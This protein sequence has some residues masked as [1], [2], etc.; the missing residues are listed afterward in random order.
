[1][2]NQSTRKS[3]YETPRIRKMGSFRKETKALNRFSAEIVVGKF[4]P[5]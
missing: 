5:C 1:M 2:S 3:T 4:I